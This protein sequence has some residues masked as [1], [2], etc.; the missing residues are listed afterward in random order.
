VPGL[1]RRGGTV[2]Y[3]F[4]R[5]YDEGDGQRTYVWESEVLDKRGTRETVF[6]RADWFW[7]R[8]VCRALLEN[9]ARGL[10]R[11]P[12]HFQSYRSR[13]T[14]PGAVNDVVIV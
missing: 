1:R 13:P 6:C 3:E 12:P 8:P 10:L 14:Y 7:A 11:D 5:A 2:R 4:K 9:E